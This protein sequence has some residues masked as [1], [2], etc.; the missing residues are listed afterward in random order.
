MGT[1]G[2]RLGAGRPGR[3]VKAEHCRQLDV[4][5]WHRDGLL[6]PGV[7]TGWVWTDGSTGERLA[8]IGFS[9]TD[10]AVILAYTL[11]GAPARQHVPLDR[12]PCYYGGTRPWFGCPRCGGRVAV[13]F[14]RSNG[15]ACRRCQRVAYAS[16]S[17]DECDRTWLRQRKAEAKLDPHWQRPKGMHRTTHRRLLSIVMECEERRDAALG[18]HL[19]ALERQL[20]SLGRRRTR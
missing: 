13:L 16:Q 19:A 3:H 14:L 20:D 7:S 6:Y 8:S 12:T 18:R 9:V 1:G 17:G 2:M 11:N 5:R 10:R 4:R 15:F